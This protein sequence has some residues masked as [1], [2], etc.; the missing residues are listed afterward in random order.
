MYVLLYGVDNTRQHNRGTSGTPRP[1]VQRILR[2]CLWT[3][4]PGLLLLIAGWIYV[5]RNSD[6]LLKERIISIADQSLNGTL[7]F[8]SIKVDLLGRAIFKDVTITTTGDSEPVISCS[9]ARVSF[10]FFNLLGPNRG[11]SAIVVLLDKPHVQ[12]IRL[13]DGSTNLEKLIK[14]PPDTKQKEDI[15]LSLIINDGTLDFEDRCLVSSDY[16]RIEVQDGVAADL[17]RELDYDILAPAETAPHREQLKLGGSVVINSRRAE[18]TFNINATRTAPGGKITA[19]GKAG[20]KTGALDLRILASDM[21]L[22]SLQNY[23]KALFPKLTI[24]PARAQ[25]ATAA[26]KPALSLMLKQLDLKMSRANEDAKFSQQLS[27]ELTD[28]HLDSTTLPMLQLNS[29][30]LDYDDKT[31]SLQ[32]DKLNFTALGTSITGSASFGP[33]SHELGGRLNIDINDLAALLHGLDYDGPAASGSLKVD[34]RPSGT[35]DN[36]LLASTI[37][38][39]KLVYD[40]HQLG[41]ATGKLNLAGDELTLVALKLSGGEL[42][43]QLDGTLE[44]KKQ[45]ADLSFKLARSDIA[46]LLGLAGDKLPEDVKQLQL[47]GNLALDGTAVIRSGKPESVDTSVNGS[48]LMIR[49]VKLGSVHGGVAIA[50]D[51]V[52][53]RELKLSD[54]VLPLAINGSLDSVRGDASLTFKLGKTGLKD[55]LALAGKDLPEEVSKMDAQGT[56]SAEGALSMKNKKLSSASGTLS[57][58]A[59]VVS[60]V[61]LGTV[62]A[63]LSTAEGRLKVESASFS[64]GEV[65]LS[66]SGSSDLAF[67]NGNFRIEAGPLEVDKAA[68]LASR[69]MD[70]PLDTEGVTGKLSAS[71]SLGFEK[72]KPSSS[73]TLTSDSLG[74]DGHRI[75]KLSVKGSLKGSSFELDAATGTFVTKEPVNAGSF[76][77]TEPLRIPLRIGGSISSTGKDGA[78]S[79]I[80][81]ARTENLLPSQAELSFKLVGPINSPQLRLQIKA[82]QDAEPLTV[83]VEAYLAGGM[84][85]ATAKLT[86]YDSQLFY[87]GKLD[88]AQQAFE[89]QLSASQ[90]DLD[91]FINDKRIRGSFSLEASL[92]GSVKEP[93]L[94]GRL[95]SAKLSYLAPQRRYELSALDIGFK[96]KDGNAISVSNGS[97]SFEDQPFTVSG[98]L[99][100][101]GSDLT[102]ACANFNLLSALSMVPTSKANAGGVN[103]STSSPIKV[104]SSGPLTMK[105]S[106]SLEKPSALLTYSSGQGQVAGNPFDSAKLRLSATQEA[107]V[108]E[109]FEIISPKGRATAEGGANFKPFYFNANAEITSFDVKILTALAGDSALGSLSGELNG[110]LK[111]NGGTESYSAE[112]DLRLEKGRY[113]EVD[114]TKLVASFRK[115]PDGIELTGAELIASGTTMTASG[116]IASELNR[117]NIT[118]NAPKLDLALF[119][120]LLPKDFGQI[121]GVIS[122]KAALTP[123]KGQYPDLELTMQDL[124]E[125]L[126]LAGRKIDKATATVRLKGDQATLSPLTLEV[127]NSSLEV[128]GKLDLREV[129]PG[130]KRIPLNLQVTANSFQLDDI[131]GFLPKDLAPQL[132]GGN[133]TC[134]LNVGGNSLS[135]ILNGELA[136]NLLRMPPSMPLEL[137]ELRAQFSLKNNEFSIRSMDLVPRESGYFNTRVTG[138]ARLAFNP[139]RIAD[140]T[141]SL[142]FSDGGNHS[143]IAVN[144]P[145]ARGDI[146]RVFSGT[147]GGSIQIRTGLDMYHPDDARTQLFVVSG[148]PV[149]NGGT[150][151]STFTFSPTPHAQEKSEKIPIRF[152]NLTLLI[153]EGSSFRTGATLMEMDSTIHTEPPGLIINGIPNALLAQD[154]LS[155]K[156]TIII[157]KGT[158]RAYTHTL[159]MDDGRS[160]LHFTGMTTNTGLYPFFTGQATTVLKGALRG[161]STQQIGLTQTNTDLKVFFDF[162]N[163]Q[164]DPSLDMLGNSESLMNKVR[165]SSEPPRSPNDIKVYLLGGVS[166]LL[167]G[168]ADISD[169]ATQELLG[170][171]SNF[172]SGQLE[173]GLDLDA[174]TIG[175]SGALDNPFHVGAEK[176][177]NDRLRVGYFRNFYDSLGSSEEVSFTYKLFEQQVGSRYKGLNLQLNVQDD[178]LRGSGSEVMLQYTFSF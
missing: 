56:L 138:S 7:D 148:N 46:K 63:K 89:G 66:L 54:G 35:L 32:L 20:T 55:L 47:S 29:A 161:E 177:I 87:E 144:L 106:G 34:L 116:V 96:L 168:D 97:F 123:S 174:V 126:T 40:G 146:V 139:P 169:L 173:K 85:P 115:H 125:G 171:G 135:P 119:R 58:T 151:S 15:G 93:T 94:A 21:D 18:M 172:L 111:A 124:G 12:L 110:K 33:E 1:K 53:F 16:P 114:I 160:R 101:G 98:V 109:S 80:G 136:V 120:P 142:V 22:S 153:L 143:H 10:D 44:T 37:N 69:F 13:R 14:E 145:N 41:K 150:G 9:K 137:A 104:V 19:S 170:L 64:G 100:T 8:S 73:L 95:R 154:Q 164:L 31:D 6:R 65:P 76:T 90:I 121:G 17:L 178:A 105:L 45:D 108:L 71:G 149:I 166:S 132:P 60:G 2:G 24:L 43:L 82:E 167:A 28:T 129:K 131:A 68:R 141:L 158:L 155:V 99:G 78:V 70:K 159:R 57:G 77:S 91:K 27:A 118:A 157:D 128:T 23:G 113:G 117:S 30:R 50:G 140:G 107:A 130:N 165:L 3:L 79:L 38:G 84:Q 4:M 152:D 42:P 122:L 49:G 39:S 134:N 59:L 26:Q 112:G 86:W 11:Q 62:A 127:G 51:Q 88:V 102:V 156:G 75:E 48:Q 163:V 61:K 81:S 147:L 5:S 25:A 67:Q 83:N 52:S 133:V 175:G 162:D 176:D 74:K 36:P 72:G 103:K 92:S